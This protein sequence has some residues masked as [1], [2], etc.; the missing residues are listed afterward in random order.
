MSIQVVTYYLVPLCFEKD[1]QRLLKWRA[2]LSS[3]CVSSLNAVVFAS[4]GLYLTAYFASSDPRIRF[5]QGYGDNFWFWYGENR[6]FQANR[7]G[8]MAVYLGGYLLSDLVMICMPRYRDEKLL[9]A[10]TVIHHIGVITVI[11]LELYYWILPF[12]CAASFAVELSTIPLNIY[13]FAKMLDSEQ[14]KTFMMYCF[15]FSFLI[16]RVLLFAYVPID[17]AKNFDEIPKVGLH[18]VPK[19]IPYAVRILFVLAFW[20]LWCLY[21]W[22]FY[23]L[24]QIGRSKSAEKH[25]DDEDKKIVTVENPGVGDN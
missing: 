21:V 1:D 18:D 3:Y 17:L 14:W 9:K 20:G 10:G 24:I 22:W 15:F 7:L 6:M 19:S 5:G 23:V 12:H 8:F 2:S 13:H 11:I 4:L 16:V 25:K